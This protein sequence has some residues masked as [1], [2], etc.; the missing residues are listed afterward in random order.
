[1]AN[2]NTNKKAPIQEKKVLIRLPI[3]RGKEDEGKIVWVNN[4][5]Y[6]FKRGVAVEVPESVAEILAHE[7][8]MLQYSYEFEKEAQ[9]HNNG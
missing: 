5:R 2:T 6:V 8:S 7:D 3:E 1:M 9:N 4:N